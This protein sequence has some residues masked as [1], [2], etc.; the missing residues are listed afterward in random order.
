MAGQEVRTTGI[1]ESRQST[2][3]KQGGKM[4]TKEDIKTKRKSLRESWRQRNGVLSVTA[5]EIRGMG[6][7]TERSNDI[8][9]E[10]KKII[11]QVDKMRNCGK[12]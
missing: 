5:K 8:A 1:E 12:N 6:R 11:V 7:M 2:E 10:R 3:E 9:Q 4:L